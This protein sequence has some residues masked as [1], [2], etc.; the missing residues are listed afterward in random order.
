MTVTRAAQ[1]ADVKSAK[2]LFDL[3]VRNL[4]KI[5]QALSCVKK[6]F[7]SEKNELEKEGL[8]GGGRETGQV[9]GL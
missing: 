8:T 2:D 3:Q 4:L 6:D 7:M 1:E 5:Q 9:D